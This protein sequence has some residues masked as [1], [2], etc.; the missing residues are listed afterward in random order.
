MSKETGAVAWPGCGW[1][2]G[3]ECMDDSLKKQSVVPGSG[4]CSWVATPVPNLSAWKSQMLR[5]QPPLQPEV[6][7]GHS[8]SQRLKWK[9]D[10]KNQFLD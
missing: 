4:H 5:S 8:S 2:Q 7:M 9:P 10:L 1:R 6:A 3:E